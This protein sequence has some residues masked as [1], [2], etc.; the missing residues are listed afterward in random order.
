MRTNKRHLQQLF[1]FLTLVILTFCNFV[2]AEE[3]V[4]KFNSPVNPELYLIRPGDNLVVTFINSKIKA[5]SLEIGPEGKIIH[6]TIGLID[7]QNKTLAYAKTILA[8][9]LQV[10]YNVKDIEISV[11]SPREVS[12]SIYGAINKPGIYSGYTSDRVSQIIEKAGGISKNGS[13]R[14]IL[15]KSNDTQVNVDLDKATYLGDLQSNPPLYAGISIEV[16]SKQV[17]TVHVSGDVNFPREIEFKENDNLN[18]LI[19]L[20]GNF[21]NSATL[22]DVQ[23]IRGNKIVDGTEI[24]KDDIINVKSSF[25][26]DKKQVKIFGAVT[27]QGVYELDNNQTL[28][29]LIS[30][31]G[32]FSETANKELTTIFRQPLVDS[33]GQRS[34]IRYPISIPLQQATPLPMHLE[35]NDSIFVPWKVGFVKVSGAVLNPGYFP[36]AQDKDIFYYVNSAGGF[37]PTANKDE[38]KIFNPISQNTDIVSSGIVVPDGAEIIVQV[39]EELK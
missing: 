36:Y 12:I 19:L 11:T 16:P 30:N 37:L 8:E 5:I 35:I 3:V 13:S 28:E 1:L 20:A 39:K 14:N 33:H 10:L 31:A 21:K 24:Q 38:L 22:S 29:K 32:G 25:Q 26:N 18:S 15:F 27:H 6:E 2:Q 17:Q 23:I 4:K 9:K 34:F 7:L